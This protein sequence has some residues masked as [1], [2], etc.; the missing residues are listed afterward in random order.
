MTMMAVPDAGPGQGADVRSAALALRRLI[1]AG[2]HFSRAR[3][4]QLQLGPSDLAALGYL[5]GSGPTAPRDLAAAMGFTTG[6]VTAM[7]DRVER[8]GFLVRNNNPEDRRSILVTITPAG[9]HAVQGLYEEFDAAVLRALTSM[10]GV[11]ADGL[12]TALERL[13]A[14]LDDSSGGQE[15][16]RPLRPAR[17]P[18]RPHRTQAVR[19]T[20]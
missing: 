1:L 10:S 17:L 5:Y 6:S 3:A 12:G 14:E 7:L 4:R 18:R 8:A 20:G 2:E 15:P 16:S 13:G 11:D 19:R 9:E